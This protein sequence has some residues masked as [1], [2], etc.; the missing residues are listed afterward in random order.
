[1]FFPTLLLLSGCNG[2]SA[3]EVELTGLVNSWTGT[4]SYQ[5]TSFDVSLELGN[6]RGDLTGVVTLTDNPDSELGFGSGVYAVTGTHDPQSGRIALAPEE[7]LEVPDV[8]LDLLGFSGTY[9]MTAGTIVGTVADFATVGRNELGGGPVTLNR[10]G[11]DTTVLEAAGM[12]KALPTETRSFSG[13]QQCTSDVREMAGELTFDGNGSVSGEISYGD[14]TLAEGTYTFTFTGV[15]NTETGGIT[16]VPGVYTA[17]EG[18]DYRTFF[19]EATYDPA[20]D[21]FDGEGRINI[22]SCPD[23][24]WVAGF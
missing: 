8:E 21:R 7:W 20:G 23:D 22:G 10:T 16:L 6:D 3:K 4:G 15:H 5:G 17:D 19:V 18:H 11:G 14:V 1:M 24:Y 2:P 9:D 13:T 12:D